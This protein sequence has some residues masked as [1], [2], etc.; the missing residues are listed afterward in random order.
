MFLIDGYN[1]LFAGRG[2]RIDHRDFERERDRLL[3]LLVRYCSLDARKALVIFDHT[4]GAPIF[5]VPLREI[6]G[7]VEIRFAPKGVSADDEIVRLVQEARD[8]TAYTVVTTD[9]A[10]RKEVEKRHMRVVPS[11]EFW[12]DVAKML[13]GIEEKGM[14][15]DLSKGEVEGWMR[16]F[17]LEEE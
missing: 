17:G 3:G 7:D 1:L 5:G 9:L 8:R 6:R 11:E 2:K 15:E 10:I 13:R 4:K 12:D 14:P 16:E